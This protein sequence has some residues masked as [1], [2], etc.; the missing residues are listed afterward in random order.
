MID[1]IIFWIMT[2][3]ALLVF[4]LQKLTIPLPKVLNN[5]A[6]DFL[7]LPIVLGIL[8]FLIRVMKKDN[9]FKFPLAFMLLLASYYA[10]YF[11]Y[12]LPEVN[13]RYTADVMDVFLYFTSAIAFYLFQKTNIQYQ[14]KRNSN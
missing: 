4:S 13:P 2:A 12:Y 11:E 3:I 10:V 14:E 1:R 5:Y 9:D 6:N 7:C 8:T